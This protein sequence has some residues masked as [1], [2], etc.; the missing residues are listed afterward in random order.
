VDDFVKPNGLAFSPDEKILYCA[1]T[2]R[3]HVRAFDVEAD[4]RLGN[5]RIFCKVE[6]P[7]GMRVDVEGSVWITARTGVKTFDP[8]GALVGG[9]ALAE[10]PA[11]LAFGDRDGRTIYI[12]ARTGLYRIR[13]RTPGLSSGA[14]GV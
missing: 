12:T 2:E 14:G 6:R 5:G 7:D 4:G 11:N 8:A 1:D 3:G 10:Q 13:V 9:I